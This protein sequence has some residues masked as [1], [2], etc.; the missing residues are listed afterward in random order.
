MD[1]LL[2]RR[3]ELPSLRD[4]KIGQQRGA[5]RIPLELRRAL[6]LLGLDDDT[7]VRV[8]GVPD[9]MRLSAGDR[10]DGNAWLLSPA[11]LDDVELLASA[12]VRD[13]LPLTIGVMRR[14]GGGARNLFTFGILVTADGA[15][16][17]FSGLERD[18][19]SADQASIVQLRAAVG[20]GRGKVAVKAKRPLDFGDR[21]STHAFVAQ[22]SKALLD[23]LLGGDL[24]HK[25]GASRD[26]EL[27]EE[28]RLQ[29]A[30]QLR[31]HRLGNHLSHLLMRHGRLP[32]R[33]RAR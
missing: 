15:T 17:A 32:P 30:H 21:G 1:T 16:S 29:L 6:A 4:T 18:E 14:G 2:A 27:G 19:E 33:M 12:D 28:Q 26:V 23:A 8:E 10:V 24:T 25:G 13:D 7:A 31:R 3:S 11:E 20:K 5:R 9:D 22:R